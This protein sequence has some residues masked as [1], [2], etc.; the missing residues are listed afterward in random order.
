MPD[1]VPEIPVEGAFKPADEDVRVLIVHSTAEPLGHWVAAELRKA[2]AP[3]VVV[4]G[5]EKV[6]DFRALSEV[7]RA[8]RGFNVLVLVA[9]GREHGSLIRLADDTDAAGNVLRV[10][11][12][13]L[14]AALHGAVDDCLVLF[15]V[16][17]AGSEDLAE[18]MTINAGAMAVVAPKPDQVIKAG[19]V[20]SGYGTLLNAMQAG[21]KM[22]IG[23][24]ELA[25]FVRDSVT[26][27]M[28]KGLAVRPEV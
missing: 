4:I 7:V 27:E 28:F 16:C 6:A 14:F 12:G 17:H 24:H 15:A 13:Q 11:P 2:L 21:K 5:V 8:K 22:A 18:A 25:G 3:A 9:H 19:D 23:P 10:N 1:P 26:K 20:I